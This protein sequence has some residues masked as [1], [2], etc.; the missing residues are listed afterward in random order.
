MKNKSAAYSFLKE[1]IE[2]EFIELHKSR[3]EPWN[4]FYLENGL[5]VTAFDG[6][7]ISYKG[8][9]FGDTARLVFWSKLA[10]P[11]LKDIASKIFA[12]TRIFCIEHK[13]NCV[14]PLTETRDL[15]EEYIE[16]TFTIMVDIDRRL[17]GKGYPK[18]VEEYNPEN[19]KFEVLNFLEERYRSEIA[20]MPK[21]NKLNVF[22]E[23]QKLGLVYPNFFIYYCF[24]Y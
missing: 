7:K 24:S 20:L 18:S 9:Q 15:L 11:Y 4:F 3:V 21:E 1:K 2:L 8:V 22:Y 10:Q 23:K 5:E 13:L 19:E 12:E 14:I 6:S 17:R 16:K